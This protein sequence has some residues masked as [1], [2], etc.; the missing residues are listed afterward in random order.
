MDSIN[1]K[2]DE[3][4]AIV[5]TVVMSKIEDGNVVGNSRGTRLFITPDLGATRP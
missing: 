3:T 4:V 5:E 1:G 2:G